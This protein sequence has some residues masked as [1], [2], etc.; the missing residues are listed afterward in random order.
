MVYEN[1]IKEIGD[2]E[3][4]KNL[5]FKSFFVMLICCLSMILFPGIKTE[6]ASRMK[7]LKVNKTY[8]YKLNGKKTNKIK[9]TQSRNGSSYYF[10]TLKIYIDGQ[11]K[12][13]LK[14]QAYSWNVTLCKISSSRTLLYVRDY[15]ENDYNNLMRIYEY[16][17]GK[18]TLISDL[19][20]I[21][22]ANDWGKYSPLSSWSRGTLTSVGKNKITVKW[23]E[24]TNST[25]IIYVNITYKISGANI[26]RKGTSYKVSLYKKNSWTARRTI[27]TYTKAGGG[28]KA[29]T[30]KTGNKVKI[31]KF[32]TKNG[33]RYIQ[34]KNS[35]GKKGWYKDADSSNMGKGWFKEALFAG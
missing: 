6:A 7:Q 2:M 1:Q 5:F 17:N 33:K 21:S 4:K 29:F 25:G 15:T 18:L 35:K 10:E 28:K 9:F 3:R 30:I 8:N 27:K 32:T 12:L 31:I 34:I 19:V 26:K 11:K 14:S 23:S 22:R 16:K 13:T 20:K 24:T